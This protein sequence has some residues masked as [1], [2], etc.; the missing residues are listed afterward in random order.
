VAGGFAEFG[1]NSGVSVRD[2][3]SGETFRRLKGGSGGT[4]SAGEVA[5]VDSDQ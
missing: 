3:G 2:G 1:P 4:S 5:I